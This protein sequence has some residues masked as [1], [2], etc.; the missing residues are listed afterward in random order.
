MIIFI[1][2]CLKIKKKAN[3]PRQIEAPSMENLNVKP[4]HSANLPF[5]TNGHI[6]L[7]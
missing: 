3:F 2:S 1:K 4:E 7:Q 6:Y 5:R